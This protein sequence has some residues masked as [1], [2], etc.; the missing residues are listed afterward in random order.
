MSW[1]CPARLDVPE[2][3]MSPHECR[4]AA[5]HFG[6]HLCDVC[7]LSFN[8]TMRAQLAEDISPGEAESNP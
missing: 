1:R 6:P 5:G 2:Y 4:L 3:P 7:G 8:T